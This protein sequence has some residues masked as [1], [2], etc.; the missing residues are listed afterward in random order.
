MKTH[1]GTVKVTT[2]VTT[3]AKGTMTKDGREREAKT[4]AGERRRR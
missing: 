4:S 1:E 3:K 2:N